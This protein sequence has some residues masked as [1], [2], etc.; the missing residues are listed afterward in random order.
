M[1]VFDNAS[2]DDHEQVVFCRD[3]ATNLKAIIA[4]HSTALGMA[5]GGCRMWGYRSE[6][7]AL[8]DVLRLSRGMTFKN[9]LAGIDLGGG[10][11]VII[12]DPQKIKTPA[13]LQAMGRFIESLGGR[14]ATG[15]DVGISVEDIEHV[16]AST[17]H[18]GGRLGGLEGS[19]DPSYFTAMG[20]YLGA[21]TAL[22]HRLKTDSF[23]GLRV[24][25]Q[26]MGNV[27]FLLAQRFAND[28]AEL[29]VSDVR[30]ERV[31]RAVKELGAKA[32]SPETIIHEEVD[33]F[34]P[35]A[36]GAVIND[37]TATTLKA[38]VIAGAANN[39][40]AQPSHGEV[41]RQRGILYAPDYVIN[42]GGIRNA[43][44]EFLHTK[45][46][47]EDG[48]ARVEGIS[49]TLQEIFDAAD[50]EDMSTAVV[51]DRMAISRLQSAMA[52]KK[53]DGK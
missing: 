10:K 14:Y 47:R 53:N 23:A 25:V 42:A 13:L 28:G 15:E 33:V 8:D 43:A 18:V 12:G 41:L 35:C 49:G 27:G 30:S 5:V 3:A 16:A 46:L 50:R 48:I 38:S 32:V 11:T 37:S 34:A 4:I 36:L 45:Y 24:A 44:T 51:A 29:V 40:L 2:Y 31:E 6:E 19:G 39:Q 7:E 22:R 26:G 1:S 9:A 52:R 17:N 20:V 21:T